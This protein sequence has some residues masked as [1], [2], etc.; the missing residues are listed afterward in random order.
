M[1]NDQEKEFKNRVGNLYRKKSI[2][3]IKQEYLLLPVLDDETARDF[4]DRNI[5]DTRTISK[6]IATY[7]SN[8]YG[9]ELKVNVIK[10]AVTSRFRKRWL[11]SKLKRY[12]GVPSI[13]GLEKKTRDLH[14]YH[15][16][17]DA[18][19]VANLARSYIELAQDYVKFDSMKKDIRYH[20]KHGNAATA[21]RLSDELSTEKAKTVT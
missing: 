20:E 11:G 7:L 8:A 3:R 2:S 10:G 14:Y 13:Y 16:A 12:G 9:N 17:I 4:V 1:L 18:A 5:N 21:N 6:Y 19:I 15:H